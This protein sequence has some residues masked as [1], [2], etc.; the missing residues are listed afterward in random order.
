MSARQ[1]ETTLDIAAPP[2][3]VWADL[4][5]FTKFAEWSRFILGIHGELRTGAK[6][7]VRLDDGSGPMTMRPELLVSAEHEELRWKGK[8]GANF[9]FSGEHY[10]Q[11]TPLPSGGTR[12]THGEIFAGFLAPFFWNTL[13]TRTRKA[14]GEFNEA[15]RARCESHDRRN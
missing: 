9:V 14:F 13:N 11:L 15:L 3:R 10:F 4:T 1:I 5:D 7:E 6:L 2:P 12:L 8:V